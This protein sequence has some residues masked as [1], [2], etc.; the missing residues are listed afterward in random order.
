MNGLGAGLLGEVLLPGADGYDEARKNWNG[1]IDQRPSLVVRA[2]GTSDV[3]DAANFARENGLGL[4]VRATGHGALV[5]ADD[6]LL[7]DVSGMDHVRVD[8]ARRRVRI[9]PGV[10][11]RRFDHETHPFG[12]AT[13]GPTVSSVGVAGF[14]LSGGFGQLI[15]KFGTAADNLVSADLVLAD[16]RLVTASEDENADLFWAIRGGGGN[17][18]VAVSLEFRLH[19]VDRV[20]G[21]SIIYRLEEA[22]DALRFHTGFVAD[23]PDEL[24]SSMTFMPA[25]P[26]PAIPEELHGKTVLVLGFLW[27]GDVG[28][29]EEFMRPMRDYGSPV[30][31]GISETS[32][33]E[34]QASSDPLEG[35][36]GFLEPGQY[37]YW[38]GSYFDEMTDGLIDYMVDLFSDPSY[39]LNFFGLGYIGGGAWGRVPEDAMAVS[40]RSA[41]YDSN[42]RALFREKDRVEE[43]KRAIDELV[44]GLKPYALGTVSLN[45]MAYEGESRVRKAFS[46]GKWERLVA[47][48]EE[49][50][51]HNLFRYNVNINPSTGER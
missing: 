30:V 40:H 1:A 35:P 32:Y 3:I 7:L 31:D 34:F 38:Y 11:G 19:E 33:P 22:K 44:G 39:P 23:A 50:D 20:L 5:S 48:K 29:G 15:R 36:G 10:N 47:I 14:T 24:T 46:E 37:N 9:G 13:A 12:L 26:I 4:A 43:V 27:A 18:G 49:H 28:E 51:P 6:A 21:G 8:P 45:Y 16:G 41:R 25:P 2:E 17:F 42:F